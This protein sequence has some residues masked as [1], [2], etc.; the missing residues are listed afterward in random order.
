MSLSTSLRSCAAALCLTCAGGAGAADAALL[1][2][3]TSEP[4]AY[5]Y[6]VGDVLQ[7]RVTLQVPAGLTL[8]EASLPRPGAR[9]KALELRALRRTVAAGHGSGGRRED[10]TL[11]YQVFLSPPAVRTLEMPAFTLR[12]EGQPRAQELRVEAW[13]VTVAPLVP[14]EVSPR[15][16]L[17]ELQPDEAPPLIDIQAGRWR[18][19]G[20]GVVLALLLAYL[21]AV[22]LGLP[23]W[24]ARHRPFGLAWR[25][26]RRLP[27]QPSAP[28]W[29]D[30]CRQVHAALNQSAGEVLFE[31]GVDRF[32]AQHA[33]FAGLRDDILQF[34][35]LSR[36]EFFA[37]GGD[38]A[39]DPARAQ[40][41]AQADNVAWLLGFCRRCRDAER[42][43]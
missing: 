31:H 26:L 34:L 40:A 2:A 36:R 4:R 39:D 9:G 29:R 43:S 35:S 41:D 23:W 13:P 10:I 3:V 25:Q 8:D 14:V 5:G 17:G 38:L 33:A 18:L 11:D 7:R 16:G 21:A 37:S 19:A 22:Y 24:G 42:G 27:A 15:R 20:Y 28:I 1:E 32:A 6:Q 12:Y 30:A